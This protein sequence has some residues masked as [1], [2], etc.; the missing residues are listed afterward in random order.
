[1]T[2]AVRLELLTR[3]HCGLCEKARLALEA[4]ARDLPLDVLSVDIDEDDALLREFHIRVPVIRRGGA[5]LCEGVVTEGALR[6]ALGAE[7]GA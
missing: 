3:Q 4:V 5:V 1:M 2:E 6:A 7:V